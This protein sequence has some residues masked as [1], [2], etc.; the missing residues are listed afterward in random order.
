MAESGGGGNIAGRIGEGIEKIG[1]RFDKDL[2]VRTPAE[3]AGRAFTQAWGSLF[4][5]AEKYNRHVAFIAAWRSAPDGVDRYQF[6][7]DAVDETQFLYNK[8]N[9][10]NWGRGAIGATVFT[11]RTFIINYLEFLARLPRKQQ[12]LALGVLVFMAGFSGIPGLDDLDDAIDATAQKLGYNWNS[13]LVRHSWL[14]K[15]LG[16]DAT[17]FIERGISA[18]LPLDVSARLS[19]ANLVPGT[20]AFKQS[21]TNRT[22][23]VAEVVGPVGSIVSGAFEVFDSL[24]G[25]KGFA[26]TVRPV[27]PKAY[28]DLMKAVDIWQT[29]HYRDSR[30]RNVAEADAID[31]FVKLF[32][33][34]PNSVAEPRR[35]EF[36][37][38]QSNAMVRGVRSDIHEL[39]ARGR[40]EGDPEKVKI[41]NEMLRDWN[42]KNPDSRIKLNPSSIAAR[43]KAM[44]S[45]SAD[46]LVKATPRDLRDAVKA[47][48]AV[49]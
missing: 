23:D 22:R 33:F 1:K 46:R 45:S 43:V 6:A 27:A 17:N 35:V 11:F 36:M 29:G 39:M 4:G 37:L 28:N 13:K 12:A 42:R 41:A 26:E 32:G 10:P 44:R 25:G 2:I 7:V 31:G 5:F 38:A 15:T 20:G 3:R 47:E 18:A 40:F 8:S 21:N 34:H 14:V 49:E 19:V 30:G 24:G 48:I 9:R 16:N